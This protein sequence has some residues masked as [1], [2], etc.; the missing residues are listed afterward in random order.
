VQVRLVVAQD[1]IAHV[2]QEPLALLGV[3]R[4]LTGQRVERLQRDLVELVE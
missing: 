3:R 1:L 2:S 4:Y